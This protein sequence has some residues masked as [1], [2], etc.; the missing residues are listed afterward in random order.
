MSHYYQ[1]D[2]SLKSRPVMIDFKYR[3]QNLKF[4]SDA[5]VFSKTKIDFGTALLL[6]SLPM[7]LNQKRILD[8]GCGYGAIGLSI[9]KV[10]R[11]SSLEMIDVNLRALE[12]C[13]NNA[14]AN[15][16]KNVEIYE[17]NLYDQVANFFD[18]IISNPPI[19]AGKAVVHG[20]IEKAEAYLTSE[21]EVW[22]VIQK[23]QGALSYL[24]RAGE[25]F[26]DTIVINKAK[27]YYI[28]RSYNQIRNATR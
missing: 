8:L 23:K 5:G 7:L 21:G 15:L 13:K 2:P 24:K 6:E 1:N 19:R 11:E 14:E 27:G 12:L 16:I 18:L 26:P 3:N 20:I 10:Y 17:S 28:I 9:A 22:V 25:I 4:I